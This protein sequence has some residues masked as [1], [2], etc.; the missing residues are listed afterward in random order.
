MNKLKYSWNAFLVVSSVMLL[1]WGQLDATTVVFICWTFIMI[2]YSLQAADNE[3]ALLAPAF[4][5]R[6][7]AAFILA[8]YLI[9]SVDVRFI[10][11]RGDI[12]QSIRFKAV[13]IYALLILLKLFLIGLSSKVKSQ[14]VP[15]LY[16]L[17][18]AALMIAGQIAMNSKLSVYIIVPAAILNIVE[19]I[20]YSIKYKKGLS[21]S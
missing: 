19:A 8:A 14:T 12:A 11:W 10:H 4:Y 16:Y 7:S 9:A 2:Y 3:T 20:H 17:I 6:A 18:S 13:I 15:G 5:S 1:E 21:V